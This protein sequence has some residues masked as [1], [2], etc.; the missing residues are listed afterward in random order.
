VTF[1]QVARHLEW[2]PGTLTQYLNGTWRTPP[3]RGEGI[4]TFL[5]AEE[6][7]MAPMH[8]LPRRR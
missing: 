4:E 8:R 3:N 5:A 7:D 1:A 2:D 6:A